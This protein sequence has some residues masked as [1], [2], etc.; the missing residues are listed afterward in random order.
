[1]TSAD[2]AGSA[3]TNTQ[4]LT[5]FTK[6][7]GDAIV[8]KAVCAV[9]TRYPTVPLPILQCT[10]AA[11][12]FRKPFTSVMYVCVGTPSSGAIRHSEVLTISILSKSSFCLVYV[13]RYAQLR[14]LYLVTTV[15]NAIADKSVVTKIMSNYTGLQHI[16]FNGFAKLHWQTGNYPVADG[17]CLGLCC[18]LG[19]YLK[20]NGLVY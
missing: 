15:N 10:D 8:N 3:S 7:V 12:A 4:G 18:C 17:W 6:D 2:G 14:C 5:C 16:E 13:L 9:S 1:M 11:H 19:L 20:F